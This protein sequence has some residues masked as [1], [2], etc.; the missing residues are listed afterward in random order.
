MNTT[1][2]V[3]VAR[4][5]LGTPYH[6]QAALKDVGCDCL[7]LVRGIYADVC[8]HAPEKPPPYSPDWAEARGRET[9][10]V[11]ARRHLIEIAPEHVQC[12]RD[13]RTRTNSLFRSH[14]H[15]RKSLTTFAE[16]ALAEACAG[17]VLIG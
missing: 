2:I 6:H 14:S 5:W 3:A 11:A 15:E 7:G 16:N 9:L 13:H 8:G 17:D 1:D 12:K 10:I 4:S